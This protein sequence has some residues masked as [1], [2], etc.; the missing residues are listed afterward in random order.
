MFRYEIFV[1]LPSG[2]ASHLTQDWEIA[3][4]YLCNT[5]FSCVNI[6]DVTL[7]LDLARKGGEINIRQVPKNEILF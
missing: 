3:W 5:N 4:E 7:G 6:R 1:L 2:W